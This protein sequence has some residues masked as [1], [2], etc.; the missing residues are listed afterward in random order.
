MVLQA[1]P[2][3]LNLCKMRFARLKRTF[4]RYLLLIR[5]KQ[6]NL[7]YRVTNRFNCLNRTLGIK[8]PTQGG[9]V[10]YSVVYATFSSL[11]RARLL[12]LTIANLR[13]STIRPTR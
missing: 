12:V 9:A 1:S 6:M 4:Y 10:G 5:E 13:P 2:Y 3:A 11:N 8:S 7:V